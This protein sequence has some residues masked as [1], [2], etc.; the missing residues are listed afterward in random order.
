[1]KRHF[2]VLNSQLNISRGAK[3]FWPTKGTGRLTTSQKY[4]VP[5]MLKSPLTSVLKDLK[6]RFRV[7]AKL[8]IVIC[9]FCGKIRSKHEMRKKTR[10]K[11]A[12]TKRLSCQN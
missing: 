8:V 7:I 2:S 6:L 3:V 4:L 11:E 1:M 5:W 9:V 10:K 12:K